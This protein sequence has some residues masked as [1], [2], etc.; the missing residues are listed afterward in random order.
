[1]K[2]L[3][4]YT[5]S[6]ANTAA[7]QQVAAYADGIVPTRDNAIVV[8]ALMPNLLWAAAFGTNLTVAKLKPPSLRVF[9]DYSVR[10]IGNAAAS[11][12]AVIPYLGLT[13][14]FP[15][16]PPLRLEAQEEL[17]FYAQQSSAGNQQAFAA[18][19]FSDGDYKSV[20]GRYFT[21]R[22]TGTTTVTANVPTV[23]SLTMDT[24]LPAGR[25]RLVGARAK[26]ATGLYFRFVS[27]YSQ[28]RPGGAAAQG[29]L[30]F[31]LS[32]QRNGGWGVWFEFDHLSIPSVEML[33]TAGDSAQ[34]VFMD[35][36]KI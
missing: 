31:E 8:P 6:I 17:P 2:H 20:H 5:S 16:G 23:C 7:D 35:L 18:V 21:V 3:G 11:A 4:L 19:L 32:G 10:P 14:S 28:F 33:C 26:S 34:I 1:M 27:I 12:G 24:G 9:G 36:E 22:A 15:D 30:E 25:Y 13:G 29:E